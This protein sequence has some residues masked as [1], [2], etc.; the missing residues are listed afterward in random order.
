MITLLAIVNSKQCPSA[1]FAKEA[2]VIIVRQGKII[3]SN[4]DILPLFE[5]IE[6]LRNHSKS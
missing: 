4:L 3:K 5:T 6:D 2:G 1:F